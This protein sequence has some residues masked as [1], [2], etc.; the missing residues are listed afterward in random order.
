MSFFITSVGKG[1]GANYGGL[2]GAD[3]HCQMLAAAAG[4]GGAKWV[5]YLSTQ[6]PNAVN[7]RD[8]IG[9]GPWFNA[10]GQQVA[11]NVAELHGDTLE[12]ARL[13]N[14]INKVSAVN[15][16]GG[17]VNGVGDM[18]NQHDILTGSQP[19]GRAFP[20]GEDRTCNNYTSNADGMGTAMLGHHD[21][22]G[23]ASASWNSAHASRGCSQP[24]LVQ[25]GGAG[26]LYCFSPDPPPAQPARGG[27]PAGRGQ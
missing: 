23:G 4:R 24:N 8:R 12:V 25:T 22:L 14:R 16:K 6:G 15:E 10:R 20:A 26:L 9:T 19:D 1:D 7:A 3:A 11:A 13:G 5:A 18:P 21:R 2:A 17:P 27:A